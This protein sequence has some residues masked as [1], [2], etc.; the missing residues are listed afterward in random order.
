M[1][2]FKEDREQVQKVILWEEGASY[3]FSD[4]FRLS[5]PI[6][7]ILAKL[8]YGFQMRNLD[9]PRR[10]LPVGAL[11]GLRTTFYRKLPFISLN[12]EAAKREFFIAPVLLELL[13]YVEFSIDLE[14]SIEV[15][16]R[17]HGTLDYLLRSTQNLIVVEAKN[18]DLERGFNQLA[19]ELIAVSETLDR[20][21]RYIYGAVTMGNVWQFGV[22]DREERS[23]AK[24]INAYTVPTDLED[25]FAIL[26]AI[27]APSE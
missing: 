3:T 20:A 4:Y 18:A 2:D 26:F 21:S 25:L 19:V 14:Y 1:I 11:D 15:D 23:I 9:L 5:N 17:L 27:L 8:G 7:E 6:R 22:L 10:P 13:D 12:S 16:D 24:D